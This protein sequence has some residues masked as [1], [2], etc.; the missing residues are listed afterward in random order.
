MVNRADQPRQWPKQVPPVQEAC[1]RF[2]II[3]PANSQRSRA[4][5]SA[6]KKELAQRLLHQSRLA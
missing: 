3:K 6:T 4:K 5:A 1:Q 2:L